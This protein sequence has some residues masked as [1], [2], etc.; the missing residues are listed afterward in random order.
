[1][2][3]DSLDDN[4]RG[5]EGIS[6]TRV[7]VRPGHPGGEAGDR[8][9]LERAAQLS[10][11]ATRQPEQ[12]P[13]LEIVSTRALDPIA[14]DPPHE[15]LRRR[16]SNVSILNRLIRALNKC[17][18]VHGICDAL[19][20]ELRSSYAHAAFVVAIRDD[21]SAEWHLPL[22]HSQAG[23]QL[24]A[25]LLLESIQ[26]HAGAVI[27][28]EVP[29]VALLEIERGCRASFILVPM[30]G[31]QRATGILALARSATQDW[32]HDDLETLS[33]VAS[34]VA[35]AIEH[36]RLHEAAEQE[37]RSAMRLREWQHALIRGSEALTHSGGIE[38]LV[39][40]LGAQLERLLPHHS[41]AVYVMDEEPDH[42]SSI[43]VRSQG[44]P[45]DVMMKL[46]IGQGITGVAVLD[47]V[48]ILAND[49]HLDPRSVYPEGDPAD[50]TH[51][52][53]LIAAPLIVNGGTIGAVAIS[54]E[55]TRSFT[56]EE[57]HS[58]TLFA[59]YLALVIQAGRLVARNHSIHLSTIRA[60]IG[61]LE[62]K[63][64][65]TRGHSERVARYAR[66]IASEMMLSADDLDMI[67]LA[68]LLHDIGKLGVPDDILLKPGPLNGS[69]RVVMMEHAAI[70]AGLLGGADAGQIERIVPMIRHH[71]E[72]YQ[73][74]G[75]PDGLSGDD[76][77]IGAAIIAVA[78]AFD[79]M[80]TS[81]AYRQ[82]VPVASALDEINRNAA[83]QFHPGA[84]D[85]LTSTIET[86]SLSVDSLNPF[87][88]SHTPGSY[89]TPV[90]VRPVSVLYRIANEIASIG[91]VDG[92]LL[93]AVR[94]ISEEL[95][96]PNVSI[97]LPGVDGEHL[98]VRADVWDEDSTSIT[99]TLVPIDSSI[100][101]WVFRNGRVANVA[102]VQSDGRFYLSRNDV[103]RSEL[104]TPLTV[105]GATIGVL[106]VE[107]VRPRAFTGLDERLLL[108]IS[109]QLAP[110]VQLAQ[111]H[112][113]VKRAAQ[114]DGLTGIYN[115]ASFYSRLE[116]L[117]NE[118][119]TVALFIFDVVGLKRINDTAGHLAGDS[120]LRR[121]AATLDLETRPQDIVA[122]YGGD[123]FAVIAYDVD[124]STAVEMAA[125][126][127]A[128]VNRLTWGPGAEPLGIS[129]GI[130]ISG[131]DGVKA[132]DLV[133]IADRRM[134]DVRMRERTGTNDHQ[135]RRDIHNDH[136]DPQF[137]HQSR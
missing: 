5:S 102:D 49:S 116:E 100:C 23:D 61:S 90:D 130:A 84:V 25:R 113:E 117:L 119:R 118:G 38:H 35:R 83:I 107:S 36:T 56:D 95:R 71:H 121:I 62:A 6:S 79:S 81:R 126:L 48:P 24:E 106:N 17:D 60:L 4:P 76:I 98:L 33:I 54:R 136:Q 19:G 112:D 43:R 1:M 13:A 50:R 132:T 55:G 34:I 8:G 45:I 88:S 18:D 9:L 11:T 58:L 96:Y 77:P 72:W 20:T 93:K 115:H 129:V 53:N 63:D 128:T 74:G 44:K 10:P 51:G 52:E 125:R 42:L 40:A 26:R 94:I 65:L 16:G 3:P 47:G 32:T 120:A 122:R 14:G 99:G 134:Y 105:D 21:S 29:H 12:M 85:A 135:D 114:R 59:P 39:D 82:A 97:L 91:D 57:F 86:S 75:Y 68:A 92:F 2:S 101:G 30:L 67:E 31:G 46:M 89:I 110:A 69:E 22:V 131:R 103:V 80:T 27:A 137:R 70:G 123:E 87:S 64:P 28:A 37:R 7:S 73:G 66:Q 127:Q 104:A 41:L 124:E 133:A 109:S 111:V 108:A 15:P 78:D